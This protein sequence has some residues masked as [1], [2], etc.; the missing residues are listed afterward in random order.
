MKRV[1][2]I[3]ILRENILLIESKLDTDTLSDKNRE[4]LLKFKDILY[5]YIDLFNR[6]EILNEMCLETLFPNIKRSDYIGDVY[7]AI[8]LTNKHLKSLEL[9]P[10]NIFI[11]S[12]IN[13][14]DLLPC[15]CRMLKENNLNNIILCTT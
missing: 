8:S 14:I 10:T 6:F 5:L 1:N 15:D 4:T 3:S 9:S 13:S 7:Y 12:M 2:L 11:R